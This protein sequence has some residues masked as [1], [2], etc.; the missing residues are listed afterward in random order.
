MAIASPFSSTAIWPRILSRVKS[1]TVGSKKHR[2]NHPALRGIPNLAAAAATTSRL[3]SVIGTI[4]VF[5][6]HSP[7]AMIIG[8]RLGITE[9]QFLL[10]PANLQQNTFDRIRTKPRHHISMSSEILAFLMQNSTL[11]QARPMPNPQAMQCFAPEASSFAV[12]VTIVRGIEA[13]VTLP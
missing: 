3:S 4:V 11:A 9:R 13:L 6:C 8:N 12:C 2:L 1:S 5:I 7:L 10:S